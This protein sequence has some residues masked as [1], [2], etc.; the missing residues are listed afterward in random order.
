[1]IKMILIYSLTFSFF[2][3]SLVRADWTPAPDDE[4]KTKISIVT[5]QY[6]FEVRAPK[7]NSNSVVKFNP[8]NNSKT[9][10]GFS[11][12]KLGLSLAASNPTSAKD[13][14]IYGTTQSTDLQLRFFG[15]HNYEFFYQKYKGYYINNSNNF[16]PLRIYGKNKILREDIETLNYGMNIYWNLHHPRFSQSVA[17]DQSGHQVNNNWGA[18]WLLSL[19]NYLIKGDSPFVPSGYENDFGVI[20][21]AE[22]INTLSLSLGGSIGGILTHENFYAASLFALGFGYQNTHLDFSTQSSG[23]KSNTGVYTSLRFGFGYNGKKNV[24]GV[25]AILDST[26]AKY[27]EAE[28]VTTSST[29]ELFYAYRFSEVNIPAANWLSDK[30]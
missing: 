23:S 30:I 22:R 28:I 17:F 1:M 8:H 5:P 15:V 20:G 11:Y 4:M 26:S 6:N 27:K 7:K 10:I 12:R 3:G 16:D 25:R 18:S 24:V 21:T 14:R 2:I 19:N 13:N 9:G 29:I